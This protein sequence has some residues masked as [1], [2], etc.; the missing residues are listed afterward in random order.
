MDCF[1]TSGRGL[2]SQR[3]YFLSLQFFTNTNESKSTIVGGRKGKLLLFQSL[4]WLLI[5]KFEIQKFIISTHIISSA[6]PQSSFLPTRRLGFV[7]FCS[8]P[9][10][11]I[12]GWCSLARYSVHSHW[13]VTGED[14]A[15]VRTE[16]SL[17]D[18]LLK[19]AAWGNESPD[20][21]TSDE[22][23]IQTLESDYA[24]PGIHLWANSMSK[25]KEIV[26]FII[27]WWK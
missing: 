19:R 24:C 8:G 10:W 2:R 13:S 15:H 21:G 6:K 12:T 11:G 3:R 23:W 25:Y 4:G 5:Q 7:I 26:R 22:P 18:A 27:A 20:L 16:S 1:L 9:G 14:T 17:G